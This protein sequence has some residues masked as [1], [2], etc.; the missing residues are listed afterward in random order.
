MPEESRVLALPYSHACSLSAQRHIPEVPLSLPAFA[1][2]DG[3]AGRHL[4]PAVPLLTDTCLKHPCLG[5]W[6][7]P[8]THLHPPP[9]SPGSSP[10]PIS[11]LQPGSSLSSFQTLSAFQGHFFLDALFL[12]TSSSFWTHKPLSFLSQNSLSTEAHC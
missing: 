1:D 11:V 4:A 9:R 10:L 3:Q 5:P 7:A 2:W 6:V 12:S 8:G